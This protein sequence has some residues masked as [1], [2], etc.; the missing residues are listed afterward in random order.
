MLALQHYSLKHSDVLGC[1]ADGQVISAETLQGQEV[2]I[3]FLFLDTEI[4]RELFKR[5]VGFYRLLENAAV[6]FPLLEVIAS[7]R[8]AAI[9]LQKASCDLFDLLESTEDGFFPVSQAAS[10]FQEL[11]WL[12]EGLHDCQVAHLDLKPENI[13]V[14]EQGHLRLCDLGRAHQW[15]SS[16]REYDG[17]FN[18]IGTREYSSPERFSEEEFDVAAADIFSLGV[19]LHVMLTGCFPWITV[20]GENTTLP[21][22]ISLAGPLSVCASELIEWMLFPNPLLRPSIQQVLSHQW[23]A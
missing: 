16:S 1:G 12:V 18:S 19:T 2:A 11:C 4:Q 14:D 22:S 20:S 3:K 17:L 5:E 15:T 13:L 8:T 9:V 6:T 21:A 10:L 7:A 23:L